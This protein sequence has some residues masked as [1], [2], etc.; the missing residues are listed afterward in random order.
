MM[1]NEP[2]TFDNLPARLNSAQ[3]AELLGFAEHDIPVLAAAKLL[4]PL[5][6]PAPN[7]P[8]F[9]AR[10]MVRDHGNDLKWLDRATRVIGKYWKKKRARRSP[11]GDA[12]IP[13]AGE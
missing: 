2:K 9:Y 6:D 7:A 5:G 1:T 11:N 13:A 8:K 12:E 10:N 4:E 3:T